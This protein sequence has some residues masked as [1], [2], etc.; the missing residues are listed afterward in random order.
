MLLHAYF[1][2]VYDQTS[3]RKTMLGR[4]SLSIAGLDAHR[5][6]I[7]M[8]PYV[9][10]KRHSAGRGGKHNLITIDLREQSAKTR[11]IHRTFEY[12]MRSGERIIASMTLRHTGHTDMGNDPWPSTRPVYVA[13]PSS[14]PLQIKRLTWRKCTDSQIVPH[15]FLSRLNTRPWHTFRCIGSRSS[16]AYT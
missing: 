3:A 9:L 14:R 15:L 10:G 12:R 13:C 1:P 16:V 4:K 2:D 7:G 6:S 8:P 11:G 5:H